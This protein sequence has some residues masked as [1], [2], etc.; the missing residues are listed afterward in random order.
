MLECLR[1]QLRVGLQLSEFGR[2][3]RDRSIDVKFHKAWSSV[4]AYVLKED[5]SSYV[6]GEFTLLE[7][8]GLVG[9]LSI[10]S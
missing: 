3:L 7:L 1:K 10:S 9:S 6:W 8:Q 4:V 2:H 5:C